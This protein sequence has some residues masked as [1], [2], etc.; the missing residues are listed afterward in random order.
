MPSSSIVQIKLPRKLTIFQ[1]I[2]SF[3]PEI[4]CDPSVRMVSSYFISLKSIGIHSL[5]NEI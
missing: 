1:R 3:F 2:E 5:K 4:F